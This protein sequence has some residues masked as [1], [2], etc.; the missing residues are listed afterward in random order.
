MFSTTTVASGR[1]I[2][3]SPYRYDRIAKF[4]TKESYFSRSIS[5]QTETMLRNGFDFVSD[6]AELKA[7]LVKE[8]NKMQMKT[9]I[10][11]EQIIARMIM[12]LS[13]NG[14]LFIQK[15]RNTSSK[16]FIF[17]DGENK[18]IIGK[19]RFM[20]PSRLTVYVDNYGN[21][22]SISEVQ[23]YTT[24]LSAILRG[25]GSRT[26]PG[27][28]AKDIAMA[29]MVDPGDVVFP[30]PPCFQMLDDILSLRGLEETVEL[31][32]A[33]FSSP[34]LHAQVGD[35]EHEPSEALIQTTHNQI[36]AMAPNGFI[37][38]PHYVKISAVNLQQAMADLLPLINH[39]KQRV[40]T[41]SGSSPI[42][43]GE[44][45]TGNRST[46]ES[47]D[48]ALS[49]RCMY[50]ANIIA[51]LFTYNIIPD[52]L[53]GLGKSTDEI[54]NK[55]GEPV[56]S[57]EFAEMNIEKEIQ[58]KNSIINLWNSNAVTHDEYRR[59]L[60]L[61]PLSDQEKKNLS[62]NLFPGAKAAGSAAETA[63]QNQPQNQHVVKTGPGTKKD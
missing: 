12:D 37:V 26:T 56:I 25:K 24:P 30:E 28:S 2:I 21:I 7:V 38:T 4:K 57:M 33:Q 1:K 16:S 52:M 41:G 55:K 31:L 13:L 34:L 15:I 61:M 20:D 42:S 48:G 50:I 3:R 10:A 62:G 23:T 39:F 40:L 29:V 18:G 54:F 60:K 11:L 44:G 46:A 49:D 59:M 17:P 45:D 35:N 47:I 8:F 14:I 36:V 19:L 6:K 43:V 58:K 22:E 27:L 53:Y 32:A 9:G 5:R 63:V 51:K